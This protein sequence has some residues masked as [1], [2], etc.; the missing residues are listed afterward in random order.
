MG[1]GRQ[2][3]AWRP[4]REGVGEFPASGVKNAF[5]KNQCTDNGEGKWFG[6]ET[7]K[8]DET[9]RTETEREQDGQQGRV[10]R[11]Q[12]EGVGGISR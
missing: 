9:E 3:R 10:W 4:Q 5:G 12:R 6:R 11:Q 1:I 8:N 7:D 2:G